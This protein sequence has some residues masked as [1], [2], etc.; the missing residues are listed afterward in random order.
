MP[1]TTYVKHDLEFEPNY[2]RPVE[3]APGIRRMTARNPGPFTFYGTNT[4][5]IG[6]QKPVV[7]DP[8]PV[9]PAHIEAIMA[10][11]GN[12]IGAI[13]ITHTHMDHSPA[14]AV[15]K[16]MTGADIFGCGPHRAARELTEGEFNPLDASADRTY[17]PDHELAHGDKVDLGG[18]EFETLATPGHTANHLCFALSGTDIML[19]ADHVMAWS[20]SIVAPPDGT[21][22]DY[23]S[24]LDLLA[25]VPHDCYLPGHGGVLRDAHAYVGE[26]ANHR[27]SRE[28]SILG[29]LGETPQSV[30][31]IVSAVYQGLDPKLAGAAALSAFAQLEWLCERGEVVTSG[32]PTLKSRYRLA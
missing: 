29:V 21:M 27:R 13:L 17:S 30:P 25:Q 11:A 3:I 20:T 31:D 14:A 10:A 26:L 15:L 5:L 32:S 2:A 22:R 23:M 18:F 24:S 9:E 28:R 4:Y 16:S 6:T 7:V 19:S 1:R 8:G 12:D